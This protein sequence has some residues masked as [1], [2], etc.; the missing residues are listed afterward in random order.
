MTDAKRALIRECLRADSQ[1]ALDF[2][3]L[4]KTMGCAAGMDLFSADDVVRL[5]REQRL[6]RFDATDEQL[7]LA[8]RK[9]LTGAGFRKHK[10]N[11]NG[12]GL[13]LYS[14]GEADGNVLYDGQV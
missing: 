13:T 14:P 11:T 10:R 6:D 5:V 12:Q 3:E 1:D 7:L 2:G 4:E 9:W 8:V